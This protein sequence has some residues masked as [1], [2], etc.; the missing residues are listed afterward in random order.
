MK[1]KKLLR[2]LIPIIVVLVAVA[3]FFG[4]KFKN[5]LTLLNWDNAVSFVNSQ[6]YDRE[7]IEGQMK[8]NKEKMEKIAEEN[9]HINIRGDLTEEESKALADGTITKEEAVSIVKGDVTLEE[10]IASK[11]DSPATEEKPDEGKKPQKPTGGTTSDKKD[12]GKETEKPTAGTT[13]GKKDTDKETEKP[14]TGTTSDKKDPGKETEKPTTG[15]TSDK[16]D[17][18]KETEKPTVGTTSD[19]KD[20]GKE[21]EKPT[22]G[23]TSGKTDTGKETEKPATGVTSGNTD[24]KNE[25][26]TNKPPAEDKKPE[27]SKDRASEIIAELY[28]IQADFISRIEAIGDKAYADYEDINYKRDQI[29]AIVNSY[30]AEVSA[31]E[32][33]CDGKVRTLLQE[34]EAELTKVN[35]DLSVVKEIQTYYY[36]EKSLKK[37]YYLNRLNDEDYK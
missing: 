34:L 10:V 31:L 36:K 3:V 5:V 26:P 18:G 15:T 11:E 27:P 14:T 2:I 1:K 19:K 33:E 32:R 13:S 23:T 28:V 29:P 30:S 6:R 17:T 20:T 16:K 22:T 4:I 7:E 21:T 24:T 25:A 9:P 35:G 37:S 12:T 8:D